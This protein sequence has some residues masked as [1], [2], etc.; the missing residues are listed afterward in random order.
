MP[1][2]EDDRATTASATLTNNSTL[3]PH[4]RR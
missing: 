4:N 3:S 1:E 2:E